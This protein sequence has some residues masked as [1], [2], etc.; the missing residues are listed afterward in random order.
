MEAVGYDAFRERQRTL[1]EEGRYV[2]IGF[3]PFLEPGGWSG[4]MAKRMG[5]PFDY[6]DAATVSVEPDGSVTVTLGL[7]SHGQAHETTFAQLVADRL[8]VKV[9]SVRVVEGDTA[10]TAYGTGTWGS[11][12]AVVGGGALTRSAAEVRAKMVA[13]AAHALEASPEDI[14]IYDGT[15]TVK[16][17][18]DKSISV[19]MIA[20]TAYF[21]AFVGGSRPPGLDPALT[22]TRSYEPPESY[23]NGCIA[24]VV[25]V[26]AETGLVTLERVVVVDDC[27]VMLNPTIVEGQ[28]AGAVAQGIGGALYEDLPYDENGQFLAGTLLDYLYPTT[29]EIPG[30]EIHHIETPST[31]TEGG[32]K[33]VGEGGTI[34]AP[35][36]VV[37]AVADALSPLGVTIDRTPL[38]PDRVLS[39]IRAAG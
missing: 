7:H 4:D 30:I 32:I 18:P 13:I 3:S 24:A 33:G 1:R 26:D 21:G 16:G 5:F 38:S 35:A 27:G 31:V 25:E 9:E 29:M 2:G 19:T 10:A 28:I 39:L 14:E 20:Y 36:A 11:R 17:S 23:A 34:A 12:S 6:M 22:A 15:A 8:G 37:N